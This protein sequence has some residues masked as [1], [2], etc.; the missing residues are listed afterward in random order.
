MSAQLLSICCHWGDR[1]KAQYYK[2]QAPI[3]M[4]L[5]Q[6]RYETLICGGTTPVT[7]LLSYCSQPAFMVTVVS[8]ARV[9]N[10]IEPWGS[11]GLLLDCPEDQ[12]ITRPKYRKTF[13]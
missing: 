2:A 13:I 12:F 5:H 7:G 4:L 1:H 3:E 8:S 11:W 9:L 10:C 6:P